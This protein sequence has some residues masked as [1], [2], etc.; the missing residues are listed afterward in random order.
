MS[1][2]AERRAGREDPLVGQ[3]LD[4]VD[5]PALV[6]GRD[7]GVRAWNRAL[8]AHAPLPETDLAGA[9]V[10]RLLEC[11]TD[12]VGRAVETGERTIDSGSVVGGSDCTVACRPVERDGTVTR[13]VVTVT[14]DG[15]AFA[16]DGAIY[17]AAVDAAPDSVYVVDREFTIRMVGEGFA[18]YTGLP[19]D[20]IEGRDVACLYEEGLADDETFQEGMRALRALFEGRAER[21][22]VTSTVQVGDRERV[23][24]NRLAPIERNGVV[25]AVV[26]VV[27][28]VTE[29]EGRKD[30]LEAVTRRL[31]TA[32]SGTDAGVYECILDGDDRVYWHESTS[33]LFGLDPDTT[34]RPAEAFYDR[35]HPDDRERVRE[36]VDAAIESSGDLRVEYRV[37]RADGEQR[38]FVSEGEVVCEDGEPVRLVGMVRDVTE[39]AEREQELAAREQ[40]LRAVIESSPDPLVMQDV[41]GRCR[42]VNQALVDTVGRSRSAILGATPE[43]VFENEPAVRLESHRRDVI[44]SERARVVEEQFTGADGD[45]RTVQL[46]LAP[47][48]GPDGEVQGTVSLARDV[49]AL[50]RQRD[51]LMEDVYATTGAD[52][53]Y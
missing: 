33:R 1:E 12:P 38:R 20:A 8:A 26:H 45:P 37:R 31:R 6:C 22:Q 2:R 15:D 5:D 4:A 32:L 40:E 14:V 50:Q 39:R 18:R 49:T 27:R 47:Y 35:I 48:Y 51:E 41:D 24:E 17:R 21:R 28:D 44:D 19:T 11:D 53:K 23:V 36:A 7:G 30:E 10:E 3:L 46:T 52:P 29:R 9:A 42:V 25:V 34:E 16:G 13:V 43:E